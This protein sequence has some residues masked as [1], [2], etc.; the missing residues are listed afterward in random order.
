MS[1]L[2][3]LLAE[4]AARHDHL[5]PR[6]VLGVRMGL[7]AAAE[8]GIPLPNPKKRLLTIIET[9]GCFADGIEVTTGCTV[10]HRTLR[11][12]DY[13]KVAAT[14]VDTKLGRKI[15]L[16]PKPDIRQR[17]QF[18]CPEETRHYFY[19]LQG[20]EIMPTHELFQIDEVE[21]TVPLE[22]MLSR[23][24]IHT[25]CEHCGEEIFN[26]REVDRDGVIL[27]VACSGS[28]YYREIAQRV[29]LPV[30]DRAWLNSAS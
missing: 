27:C 26:E 12:E 5:C 7:A 30:K 14:F 11:V 22:E 25:S 2:K 19:Q 24:G 6:Q 15:R 29:D 13:G 9:D 23:P 16:H 17:A 18:Y 20:Y 4:S 28:A 21:L 10:G 3:T 1:D 8:L